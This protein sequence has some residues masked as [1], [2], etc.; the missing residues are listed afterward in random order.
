MHNKLL[1]LLTIMLVLITG[2]AE[3]ENSLNEFPAG[4]K[5]KA[6][7]ERGR[8][9]IEIMGCNDCHTP[10]YLV[11]RSNIPEEDWLVVPSVSTV[12]SVLFIQPT[13]DYWLKTSQKRIG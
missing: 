10:D 13:C 12:I 6:D 8:Y 7:V 5:R 11:R 9:V 3:S 4:S 2:C 1:V